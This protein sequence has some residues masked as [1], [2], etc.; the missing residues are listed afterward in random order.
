MRIRR[1]AGEPPQLRS[2]QA[3]NRHPPLSRNVFGTSRAWPSRPVRNM[4]RNVPSCTSSPWASLAESTGSRLTYSPDGNDYETPGPT[5]HSPNAL[6]AIRWSWII[7]NIHEV[8]LHIASD[9]S[10]SARLHHRFDSRAELVGNHTRSR[11]R[12]S[13]PRNTLPFGR[14]VLPGAGPQIS[15]SAEQFSSCGAELLG[16]GRRLQRGE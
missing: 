1:T 15:C 3:R 9:K 12:Q 8:S 13:S 2:V 16:A 6:R 4:R 7:F 10:I 11:H 5:H 14:H